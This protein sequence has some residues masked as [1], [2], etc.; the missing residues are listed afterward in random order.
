[1]T[2]NPRR[3]GVRNFDHSNIGSWPEYVAAQKALDALAQALMHR[4]KQ[5]TTRQAWLAL[6]A[7]MA[8]VLPF[9]DAC[10]DRHGSTDLHWTAAPWK[11]DRDPDGDWLHCRYYCPT[12]DKTW[13]CGWSLR[14]LDY[15]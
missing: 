11:V 15:T 8:S 1:V 5:P 10:P 6:V 3:H 7:D 9:S 2:A 14:T 12:H 13:T 4:G